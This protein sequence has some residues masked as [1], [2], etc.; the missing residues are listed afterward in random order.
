RLLL[1][2]EMEKVEIGQSANLDVYVVAMDESTKKKAFTVVRDLRD[3]G[4]SADMDFNGR[5]V[6]AQMKSAD[7][8][9]AAYVIVIGETELE[10]GN[11]ALKEMATGEQQELAFEAI[12]GVILENK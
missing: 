7:R 4:I 6:K 8:K 12:A 11:V 1:A 5:K 3:N 9:Q 10:T 2:L